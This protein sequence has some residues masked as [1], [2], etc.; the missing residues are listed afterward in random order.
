MT[1]CENLQEL[2]NRWNGK[3][4][5]M[6]ALEQL[7]K[8]DRKYYMYK[9][10]TGRHIQPGDGLCVTL[11]GGGRKVQVGEEELED[12][13]KEIYPTIDEVILEAIRRWHADDT[14]K[15]YSVIYHLKPD[16]PEYNGEHTLRYKSEFSKSIE[17]RL[18]AKNEQEALE[19]A[20]SGY[21]VQDLCEIGKPSIWEMTKNWSH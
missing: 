9:L 18:T 13:E 20:A 7:A 16:G 12:W 17:V 5:P 1:Q 4:R 19:K 10:E 6:N 11:Y 15:N 3:E 2:V 21:S 14:I 8:W